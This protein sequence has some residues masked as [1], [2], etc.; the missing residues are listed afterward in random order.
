[1]NSGDTYSPLAPATVLNTAQVGH[2]ERS[3]G[4]RVYL[5]NI[6]EIYQDI[7]GNM[8]FLFVRMRI[9][10]GIYPLVMST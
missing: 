5:W 7:E 8:R 2:V 6:L 4:H 9:C 3:G 1:V 10:D